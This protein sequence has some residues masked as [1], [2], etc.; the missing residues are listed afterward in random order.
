MNPPNSIPPLSHR[1]VSYGMGQWDKT[2]NGGTPR[3]TENGAVSLKAL[4]ANVLR[5]VPHGTN[6]GTSMGQSPK[7][8][9]QEAIF[10]GRFVPRPK[11][12]VLPQ[13]SST[14]LTPAKH[15]PVPPDAPPLTALARFERDPMG[16]VEWLTS[17]NHGQ[18]Q[19]LVPRWAAAIR[20]EAR[21]RLQEAGE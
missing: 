17:Q 12:S 21:Q 3:G 11:A 1:P 2:P 7:T 15:P 18:P 13:L 20:A 6:G 8:V 19:T 9:G 4:A 16:V 5:S 14:I 10:P